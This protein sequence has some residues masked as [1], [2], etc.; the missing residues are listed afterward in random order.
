MASSKRFLPFVTYGHAL[1]CVCECSMLLVR[2]ISEEMK[3]NR[4][5]TPILSFDNMMRQFM[6]LSALVRRAIMVSRHLESL[7]GLNR[8]PK[9]GLLPTLE[10]VL[11]VLSEHKIDVATHNSDMDAMIDAEEDDFSDIPGCRPVTL[12]A[13]LLRDFG[14]VAHAVPADWLEGV[15]TEFRLLAAR[16]AAAAIRPS[17]PAVRVGHVM[18]R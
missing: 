3:L 12:I 15:P 5:E 17:S 7:A 18:E 4:S 11:R 8:A 14:M 2:R 1:D 16:T 10:I 13:E 6:I 9:I